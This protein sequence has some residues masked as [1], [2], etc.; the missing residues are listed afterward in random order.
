MDRKF[1]ERIQDAGWGVE[2]VTENRCVGVCQR[3]GCAVRIVINEGDDIPV[4]K[5]R[6]GSLQEHAVET[7]DDIRHTLMERR[8]RLGLIIAQ[9]EEVA[10]MSDDHVA[11]MEAGSDLKRP[12]LETLLLWCQTL[13]M[14][15]VLRPGKVPRQTLEVMS[16]GMSQARRKRFNQ[17]YRRRG[18]RRKV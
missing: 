17:E 15:L 1:L 9:V 4:C 2:Q 13:G 11:K 10:G 12:Q 8:M 14:E 3:E 18:L 5:D 7:M 6:P 16:G